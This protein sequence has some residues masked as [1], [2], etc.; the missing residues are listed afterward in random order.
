M[1]WW[2]VALAWSGWAVAVAAA[3]VLRRR[4]VVMADAEHELRGAATAIGLA[5]ERMARTGSMAE[6]E[7][8]VWLQLDR[9][10]AGLADLAAARGGGRAPAG[11]SLDA[12]RLAQVLANVAGNAAEHGVGPVEV[13]ARREGAVVRLEIANRVG[14]APARAQ[15]GRGRGVAIAARAASRL[16]GRLSVESTDGVTRAVVELPGDRPAAPDPRRRAA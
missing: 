8:L 5:A 14:G 7:G 9:M 6:L 16:G 2:G 11:G 1:S 10:T 3:L 15:R 4:L 12:G 13:L